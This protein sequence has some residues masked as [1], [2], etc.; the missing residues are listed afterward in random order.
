MRSAVTAILFGLLA[1][2]LSSGCGS[3]VVYNSAPAPSNDQGAEGEVLIYDRSG[4]VWDVTHAQK[5][6]MVLSGFE[7]GLGPFVI[8]PI[9]DP[10]MLSPGDMSYPYDD[11]NF[12][13]LGTSLNGF[14]RAYPIEIMSNHEIANEQFGDAHVAVAY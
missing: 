8:K 13:V 1:L 14:T 9:M 6:G 3:D 7:N 5:Y 11:Q 10:Q 4:K 2:L 12:R